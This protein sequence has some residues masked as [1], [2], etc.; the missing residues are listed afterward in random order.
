MAFDMYGIHMS[1]FVCLFRIVNDT[2][3]IYLAFSCG[4]DFRVID[5]DGNPF[6]FVKILVVIVMMTMINKNNLSYFV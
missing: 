6:R 2:F 5:G 1:L 3:I 4:Y